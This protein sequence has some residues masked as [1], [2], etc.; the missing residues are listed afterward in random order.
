MQKKYQLTFQE[1]YI[2]RKDSNA[3]PRDYGKD[4]THYLTW[5]KTFYH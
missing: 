5:L 2:L 3:Q 4:A 1:Y